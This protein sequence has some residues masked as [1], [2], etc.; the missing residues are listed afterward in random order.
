MPAFLTIRLD[1]V[2]VTIVLI[3]AVGAGFMIRFLVALLVEEQQ[4]HAEAV[5]LKRRPHLVKPLHRQRND[6]EI[7]R[8]N[9]LAIQGFDRRHSR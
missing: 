6:R 4:T 7:N 9:D 2:A 5:V 8:L 3:C 1:P